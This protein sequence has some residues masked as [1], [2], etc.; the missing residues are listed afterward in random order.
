MKVCSLVFLVCS[1]E[2]R[3]SVVAAVAPP[4]VHQPHCRLTSP[5]SEVLKSEFDTLNVEVLK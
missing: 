4:G 2:D 3:R 1:C 5:C